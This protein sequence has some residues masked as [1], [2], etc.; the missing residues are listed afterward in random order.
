M[1]N[2]YT[3]FSDKKKAEIA[4]KFMGPSGTRVSLKG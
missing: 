3:L 4:V 1:Q 2:P